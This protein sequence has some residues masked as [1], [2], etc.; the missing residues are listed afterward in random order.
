[1]AFTIF[2]KIDKSIFDGEKNWVFF[3]DKNE[4]LM[5]LCGKIFDKDALFYTLYQVQK[6][7]H[8][9]LDFDGDDYLLKIILSSTDKKFEEI[10]E[11]INN[12]L[13]NYEYYILQM[14]HVKDIKEQIFKE[15]YSQLQKKY[16]ISENLNN[17]EK[18]FDETS[19]N[20]YCPTCNDSNDV[21]YN[22]IENTFS[23]DK[24]EFPVEN[25]IDKLLKPWEEQFKEELKDNF[26][27][28][29]DKK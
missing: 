24:F 29:L 28:L 13:I 8:V 15:V 14:Q 27:P 23:V 5:L 2:K 12:S 21:Q 22:N 25:D 9:I 10:V 20:E 11:E 4:I 6:Y 1:M 18:Y 3:P 7:G 19:D 26:D 16:V 17:D